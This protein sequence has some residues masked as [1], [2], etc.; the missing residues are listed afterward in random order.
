LSPREGGVGG[1]RIRR[2]E[3]DDLRASLVGQRVAQG[4]VG[5]L[6]QQGLG[7]CQGDGW[8]GRKLAGEML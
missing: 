1:R 4:A 6:V 2:R 5:T 7:L 8:A 3:I